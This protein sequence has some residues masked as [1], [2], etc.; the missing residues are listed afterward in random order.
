[1]PEKNLSKVE[2]EKSLENSKESLDI[3]G[4]LDKVDSSMDVADLMEGVEDGLSE[5]ASKGKEKKGG[6]VLKKKKGI[7]KG[8][9]KIKPIRPL[10]S[11]N[12]MRRKVIKEMISEQKKLI[13]DLSSAKN[14]YQY[15][16]KVKQ[17]RSLKQKIS[18]FMKA[19]ID[20]IKD[21]YLKYFGKK[22]GIKEEDIPD[23]E[24]N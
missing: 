22:H 2:K 3:S 21:L 15:A 11:V 18:D 12:V 14:P 23:L 10:P 7:V 4:A 24:E 6:G 9:K 19:A 20:T 1:M 8:K 13:R 17:I 5:T 16:E